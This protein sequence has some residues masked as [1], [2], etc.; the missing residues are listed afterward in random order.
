MPVWKRKVFQSFET[1]MPMTIKFY[2]STFCGMLV[3]EVRQMTYFDKNHVE[4]ITFITDEA[5]QIFGNKRI[6]ILSIFQSI[7]SFAF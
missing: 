2:L 1:L 4:Q 7:S 5:S 3:S 6:A